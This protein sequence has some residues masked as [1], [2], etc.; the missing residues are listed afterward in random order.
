[1]VLGLDSINIG[2]SNLVIWKEGFMLIL[3]DKCKRAKKR[4]DKNDDV[5]RHLR[6]KTEFITE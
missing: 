3:E 4:G 2:Y 1:L 6:L 5:N